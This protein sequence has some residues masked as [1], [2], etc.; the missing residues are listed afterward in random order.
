MSERLFALVD[1]QVVIAWA[2]LSD[3]ATAT[4]Q[5]PISQQY[6]REL[7]QSRAFLEKYVPNHDADKKTKNTTDVFNDWITGFQDFIRHYVS[8]LSVSVCLCV[9]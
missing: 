4:P 6:V 5:Q 3:M 9:R 7:L 1:F 8:C 2:E